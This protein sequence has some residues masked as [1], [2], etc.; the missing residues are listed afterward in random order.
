MAGTRQHK[1]A[2]TSWAHSNTNAQRYKSQNF[3]CDYPKG[4]PL[5]LL[6]SQKPDG[7]LPSPSPRVMLF[8]INE[9]L[10]VAF[11]RKTRN[12]PGFSA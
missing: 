5:W 1:P 9:V 8:D 10:I 2:R 12:L 7:R 4:V 6:S 3:S 11:R